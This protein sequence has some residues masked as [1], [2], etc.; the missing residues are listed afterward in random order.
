MPREDRLVRDVLGDH[1]LAEALGGDQDEVAGLGQKLQAQG[2]LDGGA[3]EAFGP[4]PVKSVH[5]GE[6]AEAAAEEAPFETPAGPFL[7]L[8]VDE[9]L[10]EL[11]G[12]P[13]AL[14][15][16]R[17]EVIEVGGGVVQP[18]ERERVSERGHRDPPA[19]SAW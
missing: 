2:G 15:R 14:G 7:L 9:V 5:R 1:R 18:E 3:V 16:Q 4:G 12:T 19:G 11:S 8:D 6:A 13:A 10:K 17:D